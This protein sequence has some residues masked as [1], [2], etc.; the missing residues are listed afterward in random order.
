M[1]NYNRVTFKTHDIDHI[2]EN[3]VHL[4]KDYMTEK[5]SGFYGYIGTFELDHQQVLSRCLF[6]R[7]KHFANPSFDSFDITLQLEWYYLAFT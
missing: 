1:V 7:E 5:S 4:R 2:L 6:L 3:V